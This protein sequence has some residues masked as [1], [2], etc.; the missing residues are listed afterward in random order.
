MRLGSQA[1]TRKATCG[2]VSPAG[3]VYDKLS[4]DRGTRKHSRD[5]Q[6]GLP[7]ERKC[8]IRRIPVDPD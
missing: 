6:C 8:A 1:D 3:R 5:N 4:P 7:E 2:S